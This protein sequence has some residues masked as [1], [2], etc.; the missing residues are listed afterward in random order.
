[1]VIAGEDLFKVDEHPGGYWPSNHGT[2]GPYA[3]SE[4]H[5]DGTNKRYIK[6]PHTTG[7][8]GHKYSK[9]QD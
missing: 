3:V 5:V 9:F 1:M 6:G 7:Y 8:Y 2:C 4:I